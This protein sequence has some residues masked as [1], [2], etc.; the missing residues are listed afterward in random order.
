MAI[1]LTGQLGFVDAAVAGTVGANAALDRLDGL[2]KWY[3]F[4]K[5]MKHL[6]HNGPGQAGYP[7]LVLFRALLLQSLYGL[8]DREL[9]EALKDRISFRRFVGLSLAE[10]VPDHSVL[11]RFR[12]TLVAE[13][14]LEK[15]FAEL[16]RQLD[17]AG[18]VLRSGTMLDA[19]LIEAAAARPREGRPS[20]DQDARF[21]KRQGKGGSTFGYKAHVG[22]DQGSGL[23]RSLITTPANVNDTEPADALICG[24]ERAVLGD[25]A[26]H[27]HARQQ[28]L[29]S[30]RVKA[31]LM[32]RANKHHPRLPPRLKAYNR[33]I[34]RQRAA[35]ETTFAT[36]KQRMGLAR[37][38]YVG[39][40]K[41]NGQMLLAA[42]AFNM[43]RWVVLT[44]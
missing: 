40:I 6:R 15:L 22:V 5:V 8:S 21:A 2:V 12:N 44:P 25:A 41:A 42:L 17:L 39:L 14:L 38:R 31:R 32:R 13:G 20:C 26:Y 10:A 23:I 24:D 30:A 27:T 34:S 1:K 9:E 4:E 19:T 11:N 36:F 43:R 33:L 16:N 29:Q 28:R 7:V 3:R 37:I 35:V 18:L